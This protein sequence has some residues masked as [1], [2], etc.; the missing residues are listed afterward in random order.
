[1]S[2][3]AATKVRLAAMTMA[4]LAAALRRDSHL[5]LAIPIMSSAVD[6]VSLSAAWR[7]GAY[8]RT[9][10]NHPP[11]HG[12]IGPQG[13]RRTAYEPNI[14]G[15]GVIA[16][17][18][19]Q[20]RISSYVLMNG[21]ERL[22]ADPRADAG[23]GSNQRHH[24]KEQR[25]AYAVPK[26]PQPA[27]H[28]SVNLFLWSGEIPTPL[29]CGCWRFPMK[30][31]R[32]ALMIIAGALALAAGTMVLPSSA[33]AQSR[34]IRCPYGYPRLCCRQCVAWAPGAPGTF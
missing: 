34:T 14:R 15:A 4:I 1:M 2:L 5:G 33:E 29:G 21:L 22:V 23:E 20:A 11:R 27:R 3:S 24:Q 6:D 7:S 26:A 30:A 18:R 13:D 25:L 12:P 16:L 31:I 10:Y 9:E 32:T 8:R 17:W 19:G 28:R